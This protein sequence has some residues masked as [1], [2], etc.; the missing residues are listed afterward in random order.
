MMWRQEDISVIHAKSVVRSHLMDS[1]MIDGHNFYDYMRNLISRWD[2]WQLGK[3]DKNVLSTAWFMAY[4]W[5]K[6]YHKQRQNKVDSITFMIF[7]DPLLIPPPFQGLSHRENGYPRKLHI[8]LRV[9]T[10]E[11]VWQRRHISCNG[12]KQM[13]IQRRGSTDYRQC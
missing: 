10:L 13:E 2:V 12:L 11:I 5:H 3:L 9:R 6:S 4:Y 7:L 1:D 8:S